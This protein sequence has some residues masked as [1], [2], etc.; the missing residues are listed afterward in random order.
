VLFQEILFC[1]RLLCLCVLFRCFHT[2]VKQILILIDK[3]HYSVVTDTRTHTHIHTYRE[4]EIERE[5]G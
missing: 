5:R 3:Q 2:N 1:V 4:R